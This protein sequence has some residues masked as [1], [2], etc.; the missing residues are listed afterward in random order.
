M[1]CEHQ[2]FGGDIK[3]ARLTEVEGGPATGFMAEL[4]ISCRQCGVPMQFLGLEAGLDL[5]GARVSL[6]GLEANI[7]ITPQGTRPN[8]MQRMVYSVGKFDG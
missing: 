8:P 5:Q 1:T 6:D 4:R 3:V 2:E 7:A